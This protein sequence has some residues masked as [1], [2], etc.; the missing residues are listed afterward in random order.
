M[1]ISDQIRSDQIIQKDEHIENKRST[2]VYKKV[3]PITQIIEKEGNTKTATKNNSSN[4]NSSNNNS[5]SNNDN[6]NNDNNNNNSS[7]NNNNNNTKQGS[8]QNSKNNIL[9]KYQHKSE[10]L[11]TWCLHL[12]FFWSTIYHT[13]GSFFVHDISHHILYNPRTRNVLQQYTI[14]IRG[15][16]EGMSFLTHKYR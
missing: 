10:K 14:K 13:F 6:S 2:Y 9:Y 5:S 16:S 4:N 15:S 11:K 12:L 8:L 1:T 7:S 3:H